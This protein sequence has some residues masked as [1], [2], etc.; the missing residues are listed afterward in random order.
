MITVIIPCWERQDE[1]RQALYSLAAQTCKEFQ[2]IVSDDHSQNDMKAVCDEF[3][4]ALSIKFIRTHKNLGC[5]GN[6]RFALENFFA[7][8]TEYVMFMDSDDVLMPQA[9]A[10]LS[11]A[12][13]HNE[14]DIIA[15]NIMQE[16]NKPTVDIIK[17]EK[18]KTWLHGKIYRTQFLIDNKINFSVS[19]K[20]NED[21]AFNLALYAFNPES[22]FLDEELYLWRS[23]ENSVTRAKNNQAIQ[24]KC[25]SL[26]YIDAIYDAFLY[27]RSSTLTNVMIGNIINC[28]SY[29]QNAVAYGMKLDP[30]YSKMKRMLQHPQVARVLVNIYSHPDEDFKLKQWCVKG[31]SLIFYGQTFGAWIMK[32]FTTEEIQRLIIENKANK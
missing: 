29:W 21:L 6:R 25:R 1:L 11:Q 12:I 2:I 23:N 24:E 8:P 9:I 15:S 4:G 32:F 16:S 26:D 20:T 3:D 18:S 22:Y 30:Y 14:A 27:Y 10:R 28:Y 13:I 17:A 19:L 5:G 31:D 7:E